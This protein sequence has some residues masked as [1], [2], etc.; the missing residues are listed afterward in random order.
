MPPPPVAG[1][2][3]KPP[4]IPKPSPVTARTAKTFA[5]EEAVNDGK[6]K[7]IIIYA[8]PGMG[9]TTLAAQAPN[10]IFLAIDD[11]VRQILNPKTGKPPRV[12]PGL[13]TF[14]DIR[15]AM[16]QTSLFPAGST[17]VLDKTPVLQV[18]AERHVLRTVVDDGGR[19]PESMEGYGFGKGYKH[20]LDSMR[21]TLSDLD[22]LV[23]QG[24]NVILLS[25]QAQSKVSNLAGADY[26]KDGP[27][28]YHDNR[29]SVRTEY[30]GW[31][32]YVFKIGYADP[33]V[34]KANPKAGKGKATGSTERVIY[35]QEQIWYTAKARPVGLKRLPPAVSFDSFDN[36]AIWDMLFNGNIP[37][38]E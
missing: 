23:H 21:L 31:A 26:L 25:D 27:D 20:L 30:V 28:L 6:G 10:P 15:D 29:F 7:K 34:T 17:L 11:G 33:T 14:Q 12:I 4:P 5:I 36:D 38:M 35:T 9:K 16:H 18:W 3:P 19:Y 1:S 8:P 13:E 22:P 32:D 2:R 37:E 24:V